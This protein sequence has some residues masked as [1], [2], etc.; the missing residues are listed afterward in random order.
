ML[1]IAAQSPDL[2]E[3]ELNAESWALRQLQREVLVAQR[4]GENF[5]REKQRPEQLGV[6]LQ[7]AER[8]EQLRR[9]DRADRA[10]QHRAAIQVDTRSKRNGGHARRARQAARLRD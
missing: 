10:F 9:S 5:L 7:F 8:A 3:V 4:L 1:R 6:P 2:V